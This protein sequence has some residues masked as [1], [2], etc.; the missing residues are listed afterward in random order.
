M[1]LSLP[2]VNDRADLDALDPAARAAFLERLAR[3]LW[4]LERDDAHQHRIGAHAHNPS[5]NLV[6][7]VTPYAYPRYAYY[8]TRGRIWQEALALPKRRAPFVSIGL[9][10]RFDEFA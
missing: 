4:R 10:F 8:T 1:P 5:P 6:H 9:M 2:P 3:S 7:T